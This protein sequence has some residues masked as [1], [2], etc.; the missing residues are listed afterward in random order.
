LCDLTKEA[1]V[2]I[3]INAN[4]ISSV[5]TGSVKAIGKLVHGGK[6]TH[7][8]QVDIY[9]EATDKLICTGRLTCMVVPHG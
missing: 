3:E 1:P 5:K 9:D 4:H 2:G 8:W 6:R 7:V